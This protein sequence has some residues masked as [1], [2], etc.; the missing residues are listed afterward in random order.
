LR[1]ENRVQ[2]IK[3][4]LYCIQDEAEADEDETTHKRD[5]TA[6]DE[7]RAERQSQQ[8]IRRTRGNAGHPQEREDGPDDY[9]HLWHQMPC[10][11]RPTRHRHPLDL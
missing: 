9:Q 6:L 2:T 11:G 4:L 1:G 7:S 8:P 10:S 5:R 3:Q